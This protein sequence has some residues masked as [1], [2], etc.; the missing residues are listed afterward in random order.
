[1][2]GFRCSNRGRKRLLDC[3]GKLARRR[4]G[5]DRRAGNLIQSLC[6]RTE[7]KRR[8]RVG[9][10][11]PALPAQS[12]ESPDWASKMSNLQLQLE[13]CSTMLAVVASGCG[14]AVSAARD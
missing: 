5:L 6:W 2:V 7:P 9:P 10:P 4:F 13:A 3:G 8:R 14:A 1:M 12:K 11:S